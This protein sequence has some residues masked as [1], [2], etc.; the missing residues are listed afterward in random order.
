[1]NTG[2]DPVAANPSLHLLPPSDVT[3]T[4]K[5]AAFWRQ[6][7]SNPINEV[8]QQVA[9]AKGLTLSQ[10][11]TLLEKL[12]VTLADARIAEWDTKY[13]YNFWRPYTAISL[14][15]NGVP[16]PG[17]TTGN[18]NLTADPAWTA[19]LATP[20]H[21][22][23]GSGHTATGAGFEFLAQYFGANP[24]VTFT[25][26]SYSLD[27][28]PYGG[29]TFTFDNFADPRLANADSRIYGGLHWTFDN[30]TAD[31]L[32]ANVADYVFTHT[33]AVPEPASVCLLGIG[34]VGLAAMTRRFGPRLSRSLVGQSDA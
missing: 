2:F 27:G 24:G 28:T 1:M 31:V 34:V 18:A 13:I 10:E 26:H 15:A 5:V 25:V 19:Y 32:G 4:Q 12:N 3:N 22:S 23:Y 33:L 16:V 20:N 21:P 17:L 8:A 9:T 30:T 11:I 6:N 29:T 7:P 14:N